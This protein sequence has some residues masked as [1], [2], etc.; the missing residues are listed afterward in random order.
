MALKGVM[1]VPTLIQNAA[2]KTVIELLGTVS[3]TK[4]AVMMNLKKLDILRA[5]LKSRG[6]DNATPGTSII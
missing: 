1:H 5:E 4:E 2:D 6:I 3:K